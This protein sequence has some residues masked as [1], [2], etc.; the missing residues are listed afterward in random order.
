MKKIGSNYSNES[1]QINPVPLKSVHDV[2][3][4][5]LLAVVW[6]RKGEESI[7]NAELQEFLNSTQ[8]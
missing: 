6:K 5:Q 7:T 8:R 1:E 4:D 2:A 3:W